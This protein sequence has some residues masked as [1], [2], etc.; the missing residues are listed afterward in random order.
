MIEKIIYLVFIPVSIFILFGSYKQLKE[1]YDIYDSGDFLFK[2]FWLFTWAFVLIDLLLKVFF[3]ECV[4]I[5]IHQWH[6][7]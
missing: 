3:N 5:S 2:I 7:H 1:H 4:D 6:S